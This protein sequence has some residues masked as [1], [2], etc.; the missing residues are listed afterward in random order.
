MHRRPLVL[1]ALLWSVVAVALLGTAACA[2]DEDAAPSAVTTA[3]PTPIVTASPVESPAVENPA[4]ENAAVE[5]TATAIAPGELPLFDPSLRHEDVDCSLEFVSGGGGD[6]FPEA[7]VSAY[8]VVGGVLGEVCLGEVDPRLEEAWEWLRVV[9]PA[10]ELESLVLL[11]GYD[12]D[13]PV[14]AYVETLVFADDQFGF[15]MTVNLRAAEDP[16]ELA[17]V[18]AHEFTHIFTALDGQL[19]FDVDAASCATYFDGEGCYTSDSHIARWT[20][21]FWSEW[22]GDRES[23]SFDDAGADARCE[24]DSSFIGS[25]AA[26]NP[27]E[28]FAETF[29]A[30]VYS[31]P[32]ETPGLQAKY[33]FFKADPELVRYRERV[34]AS[35]FG[36]LPNTFEGCG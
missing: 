27:E 10:E 19:D 26:T 30:F 3:T 12:V 18:M 24:V 22:I 8:F 23:T 17:L 5:T 14:L 16:A 15:Q 35:G 21:V 33:A 32:V 13:T 20:D 6:E 1:R 9:A 11:A 36:P 29:S 2:Q 28:D 4:G 25:Y 31:L 34:Q 7:F